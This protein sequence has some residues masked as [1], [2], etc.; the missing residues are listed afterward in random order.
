MRTHAEVGCRGTATRECH[1]RACGREET[2]L[3]EGT[4]A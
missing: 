3:H 1:A 4:H 2:R